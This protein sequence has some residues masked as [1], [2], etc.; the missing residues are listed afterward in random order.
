VSGDG[1][2]PSGQA[3]DVDSDCPPTR[4]DIA[5]DQ[6]TVTTELGTANTL[7]VTLSASSGFAGHVDLAATVADPGGSP[8]QGWSIVLDATG[9]DLPRNGT[10]TAHAT[11]S[12][13]TQ[14]EGLAA[15]AKLTASSSAMSGTASATS[16]FTVLNQYTIGVS[17]GQ[18]GLCVYPPPGLTTLTVG[19]KLRWLNNSSSTTIVIHVDGNGTG[20]AHQS[21]SA[22]S[23]PGSAYECTITGV[24]DP[25]MPA[26]WYCHSPGGTIVTG[27]LFQTVP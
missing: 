23:P 3:G 13:P 15:T 17:V 7:T 24:S 25:G 8:L 11:V 1:C 26:D 9:V 16:S 6:P 27:L 21:T 5:V 12:I 10:A 4:L 20:C 22:G 18:D 2:C 14:N 19:S